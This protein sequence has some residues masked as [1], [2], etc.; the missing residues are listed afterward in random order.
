MS[1]PPR[2]WARPAASE[3]YCAIHAIADGSYSTKCRGKWS[4]AEPDTH[5]VHGDPPLDQCCRGCIAV[6]LGARTLTP[7]ERPMPVF[8]I[9]DQV[10][11]AVIP[12]MDA[13]EEWK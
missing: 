2:M 3:S 6:I 9:T 5:V 7:I 4:T 11:P 12:E 10:F 8:D 1:E 13:A